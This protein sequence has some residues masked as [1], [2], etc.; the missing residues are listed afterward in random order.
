[1]ERGTAVATTRSPIVRYL[2]R[3][4]RVRSC[5]VAVGQSSWSQYREN[6]GPP[7][8]ALDDSN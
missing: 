7:R 6:Y 5:V 4:E 1:M 3:G 8:I 2:R